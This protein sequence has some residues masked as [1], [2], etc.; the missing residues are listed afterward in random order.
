MYFGK[1]VNCLGI[2]TEMEK[3]RQDH[4][5]KN[6]KAWIFLDLYSLTEPCQYLGISW[7]IDICDRLV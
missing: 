4:T 2:V 3:L 7:Q 6:I 5:E 1:N